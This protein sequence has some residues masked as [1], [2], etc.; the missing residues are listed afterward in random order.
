MHWELGDLGIHAGLFVYPSF[1]PKPRFLIPPGGHCLGLGSVPSQKWSKS[2][3]SSPE[4]CMPG[5]P[6]TLFPLTCFVLTEVGPSPWKRVFQE[7][8]LGEWGWE[9]AQGSNLF[10][11]PWS[12]GHGGVLTSRS[13]RQ[14]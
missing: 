10:L 3:E 12:G 13:L 2:V 4:E 1:L 11:P 6:G 5:L 9:T 14:L 8:K 7:E